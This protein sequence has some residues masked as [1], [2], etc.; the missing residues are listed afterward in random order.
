[1]DKV[2]DERRKGDINPD[3]SIIA[4]MWKLVG[5]SA[6]GR[7]G[8]N[9]SKFSKTLYGDEK[10][11]FKEIGSMFF[12]DANQYG[13][14]FEITKNKRNTHQD[15]PIQIACSIYDDAKLLMSQFY[16][17]CVDKFIDRADF[18]YVEMDTDSAYMALTDDFEKLIK[19]EMRDVYE[20][21]KH[22]WFMRTD[23]NENKAFDKRRPGLFKPEF[24]GK[25]IVALSSKMYYVKGFDDKDKFSCKG[26]QKSNNQDII[27]YEKY[28]NIV[29]GEEKVYNVINKGMRILNS[30]QVNKSDDEVNQDRTI[31][32][33]QMQKKG[34]SSCYDKRII[35]ADGISSVPLNI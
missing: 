19:P 1:M 4:E 23:T 30:K 18:Q 8:M 16:Y 22:K 27:N 29:L 20:A 24:I 7:T 13:D 28:K 10:K 26:I 17:D 34:L 3:Y 12:K 5:N 15:M 14:L 21:E 32:A 33:Y 25:G 35:L 9:K 31:Y 2:S 11:Y 6:F